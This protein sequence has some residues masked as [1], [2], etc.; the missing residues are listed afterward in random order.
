MYNLAHMSWLAGPLPGTSESDSLVTAEVG[1]RR[2][3]KAVQQALL[4]S[5]QAWRGTPLHQ[6]LYSS[7]VQGSGLT[8]TASLC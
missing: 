2:N 3:A 6:V 4:T 8:M 7:M 1:T 5:L